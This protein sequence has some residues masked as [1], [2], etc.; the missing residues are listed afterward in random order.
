MA[1]TTL[2]LLTVGD[3]LGSLTNTTVKFRIPKPA[4]AVVSDSTSD[5]T[6]ELRVP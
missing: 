5:A 1:Y 3:V 4:V 6:A 2:I